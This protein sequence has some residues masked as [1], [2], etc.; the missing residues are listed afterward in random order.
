MQTFNAKEAYELVTDEAEF[1]TW[2]HAVYQEMLAEINQFQLSIDPSLSF[3]DKATLLHKLMDYHQVGMSCVN[4]MRWKI[5]TAS[6]LKV[7]DDLRVE[8]DDV[9][10]PTNYT[11]P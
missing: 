5:D 6:K 1:L 3:S 2:L 9:L 10:N 8:F 4:G 7:L 11:H